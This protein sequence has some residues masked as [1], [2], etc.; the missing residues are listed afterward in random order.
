MRAVAHPVSLL[1]FRM[2]LGRMLGR[3]HHTHF[4]DGDTEFSDVLK[5]TSQSELE[6]DL[7]PGLLKE[8]FQ[9]HHHWPAYMIM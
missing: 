6:L 1:I 5:V 4:I 3:R 7:N 2:V 9:L 8:L